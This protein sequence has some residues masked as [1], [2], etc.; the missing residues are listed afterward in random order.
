MNAAEIRAALDNAFDTALIHFSHSDYLRDFI[1]YFYFS[2]Y[3]ADVMPHF[4]LKYRFVNCV[5]AESATTLSAETWRGSLDENLVGPLEDVDHEKANGWVWA[6]RHGSMYPGATLVESS[7]T[8]DEWSQTVGIQFHEAV[9][10]APPVRI[11]LI[12]S[13]LVVEPAVPGEAPFVVEEPLGYRGTAN[14]PKN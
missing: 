2:T 12:F 7:A 5:V 1:A 9:L 4:I 3:D 11:R 10:D 6:T 13:D 14:D 8:A